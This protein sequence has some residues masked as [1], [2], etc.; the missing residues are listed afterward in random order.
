MK[1]FG[2]AVAVAIGL[3]V[4]AMNVPVSAH[5]DDERGGQGNSKSGKHLFERDTYGGNGRTCSTCHSEATGTVSPDDAQRRYARNPGDPLFVHD[6]SDDFQ[7]NG[8]SRM[9]RDATVLVEIP[10]PPNVALADDPAARS[11]I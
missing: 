8:V 3:Q 1:L 5:D 4:V 6:G 2:Y 9:L 11:V 7:G 10:L